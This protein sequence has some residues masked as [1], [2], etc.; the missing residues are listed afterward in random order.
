MQAQRLLLDA[1]VDDPAARCHVFQFEKGAQRGRRPLRKTFR[2]VLDEQP[3]G[4]AQPLGRVRDL[5]H[6]RR[7]VR[8]VALVVVGHHQRQARQQEAGTQLRRTLQLGDRTGIVLVHE[9]AARSILDVGVEH[10]GFG[11]QKQPAEGGIEVDGNGT[12]H[13]LG[14]LLD[15]GPRL[16]RLSL[17]AR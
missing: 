14:E 2:H 17:D 7:P 4:G 6:L 15:G 16:R 1:V 13:G 5:C 8:E 12:G 11:R 9:R 10:G 3:L